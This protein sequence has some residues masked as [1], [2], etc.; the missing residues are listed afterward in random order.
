MNYY[1][2]LADPSGRPI[3]P[4]QRVS[5]PLTTAQPDPENYQACAQRAARAP[6]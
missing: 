2:H 3:P 5:H 6:R 4:G 1:L